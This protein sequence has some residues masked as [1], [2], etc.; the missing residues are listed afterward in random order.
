M[1][2]TP[3]ME[4]LWKKTEAKRKAYREANPDQVDKVICPFTDDM[5]CIGGCT[6]NRER[7]CV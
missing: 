1:K 2:R 7:A 6:S 5:K 3:E 4:E